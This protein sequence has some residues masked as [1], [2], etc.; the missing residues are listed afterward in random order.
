[1]VSMYREFSD[2]SPSAVRSFLIA[3]FRLC[4]KSTKVSDDHSFCRISSRVTTSPGFSSRTD[5]MQNGWPDRRIR[6]PCLRSSRCVRF[7]WN[8]PKRNTRP[9]GLGD[10]VS[11]TVHFSKRHKAL[12]F[13]RI[14][15][16]LES[17]LN[18]ILRLSGLQEITATGI[19]L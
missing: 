11:T 9:V 12:L 17:N 2:E 7:A 4:S 5:R 8:T 3:V 19:A 13:L 1:M 14:V 18:R 15:V 6:T 10:F 16:T